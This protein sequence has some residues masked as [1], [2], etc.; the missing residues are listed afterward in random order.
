M[1]HL[2][3]TQNRKKK[4]FNKNEDIFFIIWKSGKK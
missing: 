1:E 3:D 2:L 4:T